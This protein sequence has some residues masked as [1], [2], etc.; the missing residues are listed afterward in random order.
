MIVRDM[1]Q[2][3]AVTPRAPVEEKMR[4]WESLADLCSSSETVMHL[5]HDW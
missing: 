5:S 2:V 1:R 3:V 4:E